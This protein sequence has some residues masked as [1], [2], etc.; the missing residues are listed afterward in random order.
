EIGAALASEASDQRGDSKVRAPDTHPEPGS[1]ARASVPVIPLRLANLPEVA[2]Y[3]Q[4]VIAKEKVRY[5]GEP[6]AVVVAESQALAEDALEA[7]ELEIERLPALPDRHAASR[8]PVATGRC[9]IRWR[10]AMPTRPSPRPSTRA[11]RAFAA[12]A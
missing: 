11:G 1:S 12:I 7:I 3:L 10:S 2:P 5:V 9:V 4:P 8:R 6:G